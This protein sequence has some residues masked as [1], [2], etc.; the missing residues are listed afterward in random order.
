MVVICVS[1]RRQ[2]KDMVL[3]PAF[4]KMRN[5][6][7]NSALPLVVTVSGVIFA[8]LVALTSG[9]ER[10]ARTGFMEAG[11]IEFS[12]YDSAPAPSPYPAMT[13][14]NESAPEP[15]PGE[16]SD[17]PLEPSRTSEPEQSAEPS[18]KPEPSPEVTSE[19]T[20]EPEPSVE[21][22]P[23]SDPDPSAEPSSEASSQETPKPESSDP[24]PEAT[25]EAETSTGPSSEPDPSAKPSSEPEPSSEPTSDST[26]KETPEPEPSVEPNPSSDPDPSAEPSSETSSEA[27]PESEPGSGTSVEGGPSGVGVPAGVTL[28]KISDDIVVTE[29]GTVI[30]GIDLHGDITVRAPDVTIRNSTIRGNSE[31]PD[32][33]TLVKSESTNLV[34]QDSEIASDVRSPHINGVMGSNFTLERVN[35]HNVVDQVH[36]YGDGNV[37]IRDSWLHS[38]VHYENDPNWGGE[39]THDDNVQ[40]QS[41]S[42]IT[43]TGSRLE[44]SNSAALMITQDQGSVSNLHIEDNTFAGGACSINIAEKGYGPV[45]S[46]SLLG[47]VFERTQ[48]LD[49][50][51]VIR[52]ETSPIEASGNRWTD[53]SPVHPFRG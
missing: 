16:G 44:G 30:D 53:G 43:I 49:G 24:T 2:P 13:T 31:S 4:S 32:G 25:Q 6:T 42:N 52:P 9:G 48:G 40:V 3:P 28:E 27:T 8:I 7:F 45:Q 19:E 36:I 5:R 29:P 34:I 11:E 18:S 35:I 51:A 1:K 21:P 14:P 47:N 22:D 39:P 15:E 46:V 17:D 38:N 50:C 20:P 33:S 10:D 41:G 12:E 37:S 23:S 26:P